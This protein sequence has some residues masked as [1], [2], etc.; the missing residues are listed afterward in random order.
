MQCEGEEN[1]EA[2]AVPVLKWTGTMNV[3]TVRPFA[4]EVAQAIRAGHVEL[5]VDMSE[6]S[7]LSGGA[8]GALLLGQSD[9]ERHGGSLKLAAVPAAIQKLL[10]ASGLEEVFEIYPTA[11][12]AMTAF[13][14]S[15]RMRQPK[16]SLPDTGAPRP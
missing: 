5:I 16:T 11:T 14:D 4:A 12:E 8:M 3:D 13:L 9:A 6:I 10:A 1:P 7:S 15:R 2:T